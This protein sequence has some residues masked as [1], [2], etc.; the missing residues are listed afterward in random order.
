MK[1]KK[2]LFFSDLEGTILRDSDGRFDDQD[3]LNLVQELSQMG[4]L[5]D[6]TIDLRLVSP[7]GFKKMDSVVGKMESLIIKYFV[8][9]HQNPNVQLVEAAS[10]PFDIENDFTDIRRISKKVV[11]LPQVLYGRNTAGMSKKKYVSYVYDSFGENNEILLSVYAGNDINDIEAIRYIK[12]Q[13]NGFAIC[14]KNGITQVQELSD[15]VSSKDD[16]LGI[17]DGVSQINEKIKRRVERSQ[18]DLDDDKD[19]K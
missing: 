2:I 1:N 5:T 3:F 14:P 11:P 13:D 10:S 6:S 17:I 12:G 15:F 7:I 8:S 18:R 9:K 16:I 4:L 19:A